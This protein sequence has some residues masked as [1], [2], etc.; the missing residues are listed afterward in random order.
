MSDIIEPTPISGFKVFGQQMYDFTVQG[1][2]HKDFGLAIAIAALSEASAI[3]TETDAYASVLRARQ[4][5]LSELGEALAILSK[6]I[7]TLKV[8]KDKQSS[9]KTDADS[10]LWT[11]RET[12]NR[13]GV[14]N[15]PVDGDNK[16]T[17]GEI[18]KARTDTEYA[19]DMENNDM[20]QDM[21]TLQGLVS[22]RDNSFSTASKVLKKVDSTGKTIINSIRS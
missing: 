19:L 12:L 14:Y 11:A 6:S 18:E 1:S 9:D 3:E 10:A 4:K 20:Q 21:I 17:R 5:K 8:G 16:T 2:P 13:Y 15:L 22:K 7:A